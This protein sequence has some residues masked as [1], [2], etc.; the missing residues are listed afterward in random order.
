MKPR[1]CPV[2]DA[3]EARRHWVKGA[4][5]LAQCRRCTLVYARTMDPALA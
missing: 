4:L 1:R 5:Q 2:C 3:D